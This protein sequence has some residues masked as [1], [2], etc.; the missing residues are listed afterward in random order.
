MKKLVFLVFLLPMLLVNP[1]AAY[2][3][4]KAAT[5]PAQRTTQTGAKLIGAWGSHPKTAIADSNHWVDFRAD[6][7][8][9]RYHSNYDASSASDKGEHWMAGE[10]RVENGKI[11]CTKVKYTYKAKTGG[12]RRDFTD[13]PGHDLV[14]EY[15][16]TRRGLDD[17]FTNLD[18]LEL[19]FYPN[20]TSS[21]LN[22]F[23]PFVKP[24]K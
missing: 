14:W 13:A 3:K 12:S 7:T 24:L 1:L 8:F 15:K 20:E 4:E 9:T 22:A 21:S 19:N 16:F 18:W 2:T 23:T 10:Y 11:F 5:T 17:K 6:G